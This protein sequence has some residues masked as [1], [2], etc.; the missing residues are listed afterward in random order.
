[1][2]S[3]ASDCEINR[4]KGTVSQVA[5]KTRTVVHMDF[6]SFGSL[7]HS[8]S[9]VRFDVLIVDVKPDPEINLTP[10]SSNLNTFKVNY[11]F[12]AA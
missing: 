7:N 1:M 12:C 3:Y 2:F 4:N 8:Y 10:N 11:R 9:K 5:A 6:W